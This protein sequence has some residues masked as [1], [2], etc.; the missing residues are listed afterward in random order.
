MG[1]QWHQ[2]DHMQ[3]ICTWLQTDNHSSTSSLNFFDMFGAVLPATQ[4]KASKHWSLPLT[5]VKLY[6]SFFSLLLGVWCV[7]NL[8]ILYCGWCCLTDD[9]VDAIAAGDARTMNCWVIEMLSKM[10]AEQLLLLTVCL[11]SASALNL[12]M[13]RHWRSLLCTGLFISLAYIH[14]VSLQKTNTNLACC[15]LMH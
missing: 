4:P 2:L 8:L 6:G 12:S 3:V 5:Y 14:S 13:L 9:V 15:N 10:K 1:W 11:Y 7:N